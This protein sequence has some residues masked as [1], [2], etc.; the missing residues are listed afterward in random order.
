M[1]TRIRPLK[2]ERNEKYMNKARLEA[3]V[4]EEINIMAYPKPKEENTM[5]HHDI[6]LM[7]SQ[8]RQLPGFYISP[9]CNKSDTTQNLAFLSYLYRKKCL[10]MH[11]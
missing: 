11:F 8:Y 4:R 7:R 5:S 9:I 6:L 3:E 2:T 10:Q 1:H